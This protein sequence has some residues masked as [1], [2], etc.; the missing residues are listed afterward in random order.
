MDKSEIVDCTF[1]RKYLLCKRFQK[2]FDAVCDDLDNIYINCY[3]EDD[4]S[5]LDG[6]SEV[7]EKLYVCNQSS[8][9]CV[10]CPHAKPH[11]DEFGCSTWEL[12]PCDT[13]DGA[14]CKCIEHKG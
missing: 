5:V 14:M 11:I 8:E 4:M 6:T 1:C 2:E 7:N 3:D 9:L 10:N 13:V 12:S